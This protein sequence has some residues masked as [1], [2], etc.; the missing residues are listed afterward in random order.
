MKISKLLAVI[1]LF[2]VSIPA[3]SSSTE[4]K[5]TVYFNTAEFE[6]IDSAVCQLNELIEETANFP[7]FELFIEGHTDNRGM[8][9]YNEQLSFN[10]SQA[11]KNYLISKGIA[12]KN[13]RTD[14]KGELAPIYRILANLIW[15]VTEG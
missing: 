4:N 3:Q 7:D 15:K 11:V 8:N 5:K 1:L 14:F 12:V 2:V 6:L 9:V 10:R 13:I